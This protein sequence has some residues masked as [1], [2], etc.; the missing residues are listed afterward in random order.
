VAVANE[1]STKELFMKPVHP[2]YDALV[3]PTRARV[4]ANPLIGELLAP[5]LDPARLHLFLMKW[6][7]FGVQMT[8]P[9]EGWIRRAGERCQALGFPELG[10]NLVKH[11]KQEAGHDELLVQ[12]LRW[13][14]E[15]WNRRGRSQVSSEQFLDVPTTAAMR[16]Y[17]DLHEVVIAGREPFAQIA[18]EYEIEA[19]STTLGPR[20]LAQCLRLLGSEAR[21]GLSFLDEHVTLDVGHT[22]FNRR[23]LQKLLEQHPH[24]ASILGITGSL[25]LQAYL[26]FFAD[27]LEPDPTLRRLPELELGTNDL[28]SS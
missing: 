15:Q 24:T 28:T 14:V 3:A 25:A 26:D 20:F 10:R 8:R 21:Q 18:I 5:D 1:P 9:V 13:L 4:A 16:R 2:T 6:S 19:L 17:I 11:A 23:Q 7:G 27:C 12:D 22:A